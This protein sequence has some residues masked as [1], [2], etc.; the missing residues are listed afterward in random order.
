M[1]VS[2]E[3]TDTPDTTETQGEQ[4]VVSEP[5]EVVDEYDFVCVFRNP[6]HEKG[7][8]LLE[9]KADGSL[10][11][12]YKDFVSSISKVGVSHSSY[13]SAQ[14]DEVY[15][16]LGATI[17]RFGDQAD[18]LD[19]KMILN[20][21]ETEK[22]CDEYFKKFE[23]EKKLNDVSRQISDFDDST[24]RKYQYMYGSYTN[25]EEG[26]KPVQQLFQKAP[27]CD[28]PFRSTDKIKLIMSMVE[29]E[30]H[31]GGADI[32]IGLALESK[33]ECTEVADE[34]DKYGEYGM[35]QAF[36]LHNP[37]DLNTLYSSW[38]KM[39]QWPSDQPV[40]LLRSYLGEKSGL[41][42]AFLCHYTTWMG[43]LSILGLIVLVDIF[44]EWTTEAYL[45]PF[46]A[47]AVSIWSI[48]ML[49]AWKNKESTFA[50]KWGMT[51]Y[52]SMEQDRPEFNGEKM[53]SPVDGSLVYFYASDKRNTSS[54]RNW[55]VISL[56][57]LLVFG[58]IFGVYFLKVLFI[59]NYYLEE[60]LPLSIQAVIIQILNFVYRM[61]AKKMTD[62]E[63]HQTDTQYEDSLVNKLYLFTFANS[64]G[65]LFFVAFIAQYTALGCDY[66]SCFIDLA[67]EMTMIFCLNL[68]VV[69]AGEIIPPL[70]AARAKAAKEMEGVDPNQ[71]LSKAEL[72]FTLD[73][74]DPIEST[75]EDFTTI[76]IEFGYVVLFAT[77]FPAA[78]VLA[79]ISEYFQIRTDG[80]KLCRASKRC[81]P[82]GGQDI[83][84][85]CSIFTVTAYA[86]VLSNSAIVCFVD[87]TLLG[88]M[89]NYEKVWFFIIFQYSI[90]LL[91][92]LLALVIPDIPEAVIIQAK[93]SEY[94]NEILVQQIPQEDE[95]ID[96]IL[97]NLFKE[98]YK[99]QIDTL[100]DSRYWPNI[101]KALFE[102]EV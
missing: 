80:W 54:L 93:R 70:I 62:Y 19:Y 65:A 67:V 43:W 14:G 22:A 99:V 57:I 83:G 78:P 9:K 29:A 63:N 15:V 76:S 23:N 44:V 34:D 21:A 25:D 85:W 97:Y 33:E 1:S 68:V 18:I 98:P 40:D 72:E 20:E 89:E 28:H 10:P 56:M 2:E 73:N 35:M 36:P 84:I 50:M 49:E 71:T 87:P 5:Q 74:Y 58:C 37:S 90:L 92:S 16:L 61:M 17:S 81:L 64:Y 38:V 69:N 48:L 88:F 96:G 86:A 101:E 41:Y 42:F 30:T 3:T 91:M 46:F 52:E 53:W 100:P 94:L 6:E 32:N 7:K 31:R 66:G 26:K 79:Y 55:T 11:K 13:L 95:K 51:D 47:I 75:I 8:L 12:T 45:V 82:T 24:F 77:A 59:N 4:S 102:R 60:T 39:W 27:G